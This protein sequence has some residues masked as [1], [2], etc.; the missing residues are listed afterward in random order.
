MYEQP[1]ILN[2]HG[3]PV[4]ANGTG[5]FSNANQIKSIRI[6]N[7][8]LME[9]GEFQ[10]QY[11][12]PYMTDSTAMSLR[13]LGNQIDSTPKLTATGLAQLTNQ[14]IQPSAIPGS[15]VRIV[16]GWNSKRFR[17]ILRISFSDDLAETE[18]II[19]GYTDIMD[20]SMSNHVNPD[21]TFF[22]SSI[23]PLKKITLGNGINQ[24]SR[25]SPLDPSHVYSKEHHMDGNASGIFTLTPKSV[26]T[27]LRVN[28]YD[29]DHGELNNTTNE[30]LY[31]TASLLD[32]NNPGRY[33]A[34]IFNR[35]QNVSMQNNQS[36]IALNR[37]DVLTETSA[38]LNDPNITLDLFMNTLY[39]Q[40]HGDVSR[41]W[42][43]LRELMQVDPSLDNVI[44]VVFKNK[45]PAYNRAMMPSGFDTNHVGGS[46]YET[47]MAINIA[48]IL[49]SIMMDFGIVFIDFS[50]TNNNIALKSD[51]LI[52]NVL[53]IGGETVDLSPYKQAI[54]SRIYDELI[55]VVSQRGQIVYD[56]TVSCSL[57]GETYINASY[58]GQAYVPYLIPTF[59]SSLFDPTLTTNRQDVNNMATGIDAV[60]GVI[61][62]S[63]KLNPMSQ[64][65]STVYD[66]RSWGGDNT[67]AQV[68]PLHDSVTSM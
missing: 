5:T 66:S 6:L 35:Y 53:S 39:N 2:S 27:Q 61:D 29:Y 22:V 8:L 24:T 42:F 40:I 12:R 4:F 31:P 9:T 55:T 11:F 25:I 32:N 68:G 7:L 50:A 15:P 36:L 23:I 48:N 63:S 52:Q 47:Q 38:G 45:D 67:V 1:Y 56:L 33:A 10:N 58:N 51:I 60:F 62:S 46:D 41:A 59:A 57:T 30:I 17:Y 14:Y 64:R 21:T 16:N 65:G 3:V 28:S 18:E 19:T 44:Q 37:N 13:E 49:P 20:V 34:K 54:M 26:L 43:S